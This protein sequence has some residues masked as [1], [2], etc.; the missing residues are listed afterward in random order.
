VQWLVQQLRG[1]QVC[2]TLAGRFT[3]LI[4]GVQVLA[5]QDM[6]DAVLVE[7]CGW[8]E[9]E[10]S[11]W[12]RGSRSEAAEDAAA[13]WSTPE[14]VLSKLFAWLSRQAQRLL[15]KQNGR[16]SLSSAEEQ[17]Q[18]L[19][20]GQLTDQRSPAREAEDPVAAVGNGIAATTEGQ[21]ENVAATRSADDVEKQA[22]PKAEASSGLVI[23]QASRT[24]SGGTAPTS[25]IDADSLAGISAEHASRLQSWAAWQAALTGHPAPVPDTA[26]GDEYMH[27]YTELMLQRPP[28][29]YMLHPDQDTRHP[30]GMSGLATP[31][32]MTPSASAEDGSAVNP[33]QSAADAGA[34]SAVAATFFPTPSH[35]GMGSRATGHGSE[36]PDGAA[37]SAGAQPGPNGAAAAQGSAEK[38]DR[39]MAERQGSGQLAGGATPAS[40]A[41]AATPAAGSSLTGR[42]IA[43]QRSQVNYS[44]MAG[45]S[46]RKGGEHSKAARKHAGKQSERAEP[47]HRGHTALAV[48]N[49]VAAGANPPSLPF[50]ISV[51]CVGN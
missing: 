21:Q 50:R 15:G 19:P 22:D 8:T 12:L 11:S 39:A 13:Q 5:L 44:A 43:R 35:L 27:P 4:G 1:V 33:H 28:T 16:A 32:G 41:A 9:A 3:V 31:S 2:G 48:Q 51:L 47:R 40:E 20:Q 23:Q 49:A 10:W 6:P 14:N 42:G 30:A 29:Q 45:N 26:A 37:L 18:E 46:T 36:G 17:P 34:D 24:A 7:E 38:E 25:S